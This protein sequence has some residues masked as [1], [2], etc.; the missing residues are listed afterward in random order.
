MYIL[1][2]MTNVYD[3]LLQLQ[4]LTKKNLEILQTLNSSLTT[5]HNYLSVNVGDQ[6]YAIPSFMALENKINHLQENF[7]NLVNAPLSGEAYFNFD[8]NSK[9]IELRSYTHTPHRLVLDNVNSP[10]L[11]L[12][13]QIVVNLKISL[14]F[15]SSLDIK[16]MS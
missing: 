1:Y 3:Y 9:A 7:E 15:M 4:T 13:I 10:F 11:K 6:P 2:D 12:S 5:N 8:G 16:A 14:C